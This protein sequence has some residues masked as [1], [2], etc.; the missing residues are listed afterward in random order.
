MAA[1]VQ[2]TG[3]YGIGSVASIAIAFDSDNIV[4]NAIFAIG[5]SSDATFGAAAFSDSQT[6]SYTVDEDV[7]RASCS[8]GIA[9]AVSIVAGANTVTFTPDASG[10]CVIAISEFSGINAVPYDVSASTNGYGAA[11]AI[12][13]TPTNEADVCIGGIVVIYGYASA[14]T[15]PTGYSEIYEGHLGGNSGVWFHYKIQ[16][17]SGAE[18][19]SWAWTN[20]NNYVG[21]FVGYKQA[22]AGGISMPVVMLQMDHFN[23]GAIL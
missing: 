19:P 7:S 2:G 16:E 15:P 8:G 17:S 3:A 1:Y 18:A 11:T 9:S 12:G 21:L 4:G 14:D 6:N 5:G 23:G 10:W 20:S 22:A 13:S